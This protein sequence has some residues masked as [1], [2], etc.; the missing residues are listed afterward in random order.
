MLV[1]K[2]SKHP[3]IGFAN[4]PAIILDTNMIKFSRHIALIFKHHGFEKALSDANLGLGNDDI[5]LQCYK[6]FQ[7]L[8]K[9]YSSSTLLRECK[10]QPLNISLP[11]EKN[12]NFKYHNEQRTVNLKWLQDVVYILSAISY[13]KEVNHLE[14]RYEEDFENKNEETEIHSNDVGRFAFDC[15]LSHGTQLLSKVNYF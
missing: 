9:Y 14:G 10:T 1:K 8:L 12:N 3:S 5:F 2:F 4:D 13:R 7:Q 6:S 15:I 11:T